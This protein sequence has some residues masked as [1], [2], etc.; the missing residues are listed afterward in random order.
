MIADWS[1][2]VDSRL[3]IPDCRLSM[4]DVLLLATT[5]AGNGYVAPA[6]VNKALDCLTKAVNCGSYV[7]RSGPQPNL[8][9]LMTWSINWDRFGGQEFS[10]NFD[11]YFG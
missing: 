5:N 8:R 3:S 10:K 7:P 1:P 6:E 2:I 4:R 9:G 11:A